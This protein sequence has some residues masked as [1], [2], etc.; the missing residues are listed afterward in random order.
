MA[1]LTDYKLLQNGQVQRIDSNVR[2]EERSDDRFFATDSK[3]N[4]NNNV[5]PITVNKAIP[6]S[7]SV[8]G[9]LAA[10]SIPDNTM[11]HDNGNQK[12]FPLGGNRART[13]NASDAA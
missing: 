11:R 10:G 2:S 9:D 3:G 12:A 1:P 7:G 4:V 8:I 6:E 5:T 13:T